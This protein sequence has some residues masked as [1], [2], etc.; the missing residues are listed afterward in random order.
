LEENGIKTKG[1]DAW[2]EG[3]KNRES[4]GKEG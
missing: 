4:E 1:G 3:K 2:R